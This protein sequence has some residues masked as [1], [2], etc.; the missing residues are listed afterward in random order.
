MCGYGCGEEKGREKRKWDFRGWAPCVKL[1][2]LG[3]VFDAEVG[4]VMSDSR[5]VGVI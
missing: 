3:H 5:I 1:D 2:D 4:R